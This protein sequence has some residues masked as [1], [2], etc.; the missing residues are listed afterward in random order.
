MRSQQFSSSSS[1]YPDNILPR[2][3]VLGVT[4]AVEDQIQQALNPDLGTGPPNR[5]YVPSSARSAVIHWA[6]T[7]KFDLSSRQPTHHLPPEEIFLVAV[8]GF[9]Y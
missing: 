3:C 6:H 5:R 2:S 8:S 4:W 1:D 9:R 7:A